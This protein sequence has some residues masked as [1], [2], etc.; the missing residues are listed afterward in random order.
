[1]QG[2]I[3]KNISNIWTVKNDSGLYNCKASGKVRNDKL[4]P[5]VGDQVIF[6]EEN[7]YIQKVLPRK[8]FLDRPNVSNVDQVLIITSVKEPNLDLYLLDKLLLISEYNNLTPIICFTK[9]DLLD[10]LSELNN[11]RLYYEK[12]GYKVLYNNEYDDFKTL[13]KDKITVFT[14]QSGAGKSSLLNKLDK[15]INLK[16]GEISLALGRG[17]HTTRHTELFAIYGGYLVDTPGFS[18]LNIDNILLEHIKENMKDI[19]YYSH[20]CLYKGCNHIKEEACFVKE[21]VQKQEIIQS[22]YDNYLKFVD[23]RRNSHGKVKY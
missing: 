18:S 11:L 10:D 4:I 21:Q 17:R 14:G 9:L 23:E 3:I 5:L 16:T 20:D 1:M 13:F 6:D 19:F 8:N 12:I 15:N 7:N 2:L 22:R